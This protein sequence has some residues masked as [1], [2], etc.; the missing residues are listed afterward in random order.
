MKLKTSCLSLFIFLA[1]SLQTSADTF[2]LTHET[3]SA[4]S[5]ASLAKYSNLEFFNPGHHKTIIRIHGLPEAEN[6]ILRWE[7]PVLIKTHHQREY[8]KEVFVRLQEF[9]QEKGMVLVTSS[10]GFLPG[11]KV[12]WT[13]ETEDGKSVSQSVTF[14]PNPI[15]IEMRSGKS[16]L[17]ADLVRLRPTRYKI[18]LEGIGS[19]EKLRLTT[20]SSGEKIDKEFYFPQ[21]SLIS[22]TPGVIGKEGGFCNLSITR[23]N[24]DQFSLTLPW[25]EELID[26]LRVNSRP[27]VSDF[28]PIVSERWVLK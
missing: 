5:T 14:S 22:L 12:T 24:R 28:S 9:L 1:T 23:Q 20:F 15:I 2:H 4:A 13:L 10:V 8:T 7:R 21:G 3:I 26:C 19:F 18:T 16:K 27:I 6:Y 25:G 11:E 17:Q